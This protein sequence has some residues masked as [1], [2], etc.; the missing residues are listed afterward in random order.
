MTPINT[1][2]ISEDQETLLILKKF[3]EENSMIMKI[4][5]DSDCIKDGVVIIK[6]KRPDLIILDI[7]LENN[8][9]RNVGTIRF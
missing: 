4:I 6:S 7:V 5:G 1:I 3:A 8:F 2:I 9:F